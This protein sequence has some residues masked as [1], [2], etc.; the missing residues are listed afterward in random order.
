MVA[1]SLVVLI[2]NVAP[3]SAASRPMSSTRRA[4]WA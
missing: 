2:R 4:A 3:A 1:F